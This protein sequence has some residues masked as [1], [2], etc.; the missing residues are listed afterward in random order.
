MPRKE[1][2]TVISGGEERIYRVVYQ[3]DSSQRAEAVRFFGE[4]ADR[5]FPAMGI[6]EEV[7]AMPINEANKYLRRNPIQKQWSLLRIGH[8]NSISDDDLARLRH[9]P[10]LEHVQISSDRITDAGVEH[11]VHL[12][13]MTRLGI[14]SASITDACL[15]V[16]H[17]LR[18][19]RSLDLQSS[20]NLTRAA[21]LSAVEAM[22]WLEDAY[23]PPDPV[24]LA[25]CRR[26]NELSRLSEA[27]TV[28]KVANPTGSLRFVDLSRQPLAR[29]PADL[30][31]TDDIWRLDLI[32]CGV[33]VLPDSIG[34]LKQLR[35]LYANWCRLT[36]L[37]ETFGH[38]TG[39]VELWLNNNELTRLPDTLSQLLG[40]KKLSLGSNQL[41]RFPEALFHLTQLE[42]LRIS[43]NRMALLPEQIG[44][45]SELRSLSLSRNDLTTLPRG[46]AG[47]RKLTHLGLQRNPIRSLPDELWHLPCLVT[48]DLTNTG[49]TDLPPQAARI[50]SIIGLPGRRVQS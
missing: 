23:P 8:Q 44:E 27:R 9:L 34:N 31:S 6:P 45:L 20:P 46:I 7:T 43:D 16:I 21:V 19:L 29:L 13:A 3:D 35:T 28:P 47:L 25:E 38:L 5:L 36:E 40:L 48:L 30:F 26:R 37:P 49:F 11:L 41:D 12:P 24:W 1:T 15:R 39:L 2:L 32:D 17:T 4:H 33:E 42:E 10:E 18:S 22:P 50:P 14:Y